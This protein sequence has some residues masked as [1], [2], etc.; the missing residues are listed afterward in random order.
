MSNRWGK[1]VNSGR[2]VFLAPKSPHMV[3]ASNEIR[4]HLLLGKKA[5]I[6]PNSILKI[7][8]IILLD[9]AI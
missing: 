2:F 8:D 3:T 6:N 7:R 5:M 1:S 4:R 9:K